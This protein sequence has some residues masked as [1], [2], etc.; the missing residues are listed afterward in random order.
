VLAEFRSQRAG[1]TGYVRFSVGLVLLLLVVAFWST[2]QQSNVLSSLAEI[3]SWLGWDG[4]EQ[5]CRSA[6]ADRETYDTPKWRVE[7][8][9]KYQFDRDAGTLV[10]IDDD[11]ELQ[12][13]SQAWQRMQVTC[14]YDL[15]N[16]TV[17]SVELAAR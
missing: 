2:S 9:R 11:V 6:A 13:G 5:E 16:R 17:H 4:A 15:Q 1:R 8:F 7:R 10:L 14:I 3:V 12:S